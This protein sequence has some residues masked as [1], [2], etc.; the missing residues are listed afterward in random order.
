M[1]APFGMASLCGGVIVCLAAGILRAEEPT[2]ELLTSRYVRTNVRIAVPEKDS[3]DKAV[4]VFL[5]GVDV[6]YVEPLTFL[7]SEK[8]KFVVGSYNPLTMAVRLEAAESEDPSYAALTKFIAAF[9][10][11]FAPAGKDT[12]A[13]HAMTAEARAE[14]AAAD[15]LC[16]DAKVAYRGL[17]E[18]D[19][20]MRTEI[21]SAEV[22]G[23][24]EGAVGRQGMREQA[25][26]INE[27]GERLSDNVTNARA[28]FEELEKLKAK[29]EESLAAER[30]G[31]STNDLEQARE[32]L[33]I[34]VA[35]ERVAKTEA[36]KGAE[37]A[38]ARRKLI[39]AVSTTTTAHA[40]AQLELQEVEREVAEFQELTDCQRQTLALLTVFSRTRPV[41]Q[42]DRL[43][44]MAESAT[45]LA[46][47]LKSTADQDFAWYPTPDDTN[48]NT[49]ANQK[50]KSYIIDSKSPKADKVVTV[51]MAA[52]RTSLEIQNGVLEVKSVPKS[53]SK[54]VFR[55]RERSMFASEIGAGLV[56]A[57]VR[58]P[59]YSPVKN[60]AGQTVVAKTDIEKRDFKGALMLNTVC[61]CWGKS[62]LYPMFQF[63]I[64]ADKD[65]PAIFGGVGFRFVRPKGL[66]L[67]AGGVLAWVKDLDKLS[68]GSTVESQAVIDADLKSQPTVKPYFA[69]HYSF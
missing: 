51:T 35:A 56:V 22:K 59:A 49:D 36:K 40:R 38:E 1:T 61:R 66:G 32:N 2:V 68:I 44:R 31:S 28:A 43:A 29:L 19:Q 65:A 33:A 4:R 62:P 50:S 14:L 55:M 46:A 25:V 47:S 67:S 69:L 57:A 10:Q 52:T 21:R 63:G 17:T 5:D 53:D 26:A 20:A 12:E 45:D 27:S 3:K 6:D 16:K 37:N 54:V 42:I 34:A 41:E 9:Y 8:V 11:T 58:T 23:W 30:G 24:V 7:A 13:A 48:S 39:D 64:A 18:F 15:P 60:D